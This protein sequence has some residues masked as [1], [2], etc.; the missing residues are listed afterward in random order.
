M[1]IDFSKV[2]FMDMDKSWVTFDGPK[3]GFHPIQMFLWL[4]EGNENDDI[5]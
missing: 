4:K 3:D 1:K 5:G 2:I